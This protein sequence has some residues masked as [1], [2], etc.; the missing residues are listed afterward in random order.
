MARESEV[1][2]N[3]RYTSAVYRCEAGARDQGHALGVWQPVDERLHASMCEVC[4]VMAW[5]T[6]SGN[7]KRWRM[8]GSALEQ[9]CV[10][11]DR[12]SASGA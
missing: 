11:D 3:E 9:D 6:R 12:R 4:S 1:K 5:V 10:E 2:T 8:G 7:G